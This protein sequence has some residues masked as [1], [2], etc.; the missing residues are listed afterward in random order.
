MTKRQTKR[1]QNQPI[2]VAGVS[3]RIRERWQAISTAASYRRHML[4]GV[5]ALRYDGDLTAEEV[6][7]IEDAIRR[8]GDA[9]QATDQ[10]GADLDG[11]GTMARILRAA[12]PDVIDRL[13]E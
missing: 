4:L 9:L 10:P 11:T 6:E 1:V 13:R 3:A 5:L 2:Q 7:R 12:G 8:S